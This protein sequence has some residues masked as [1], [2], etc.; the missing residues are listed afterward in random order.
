M[1]VYL[2]LCGVK[3]PVGK[4]PTPFHG[5]FGQDHIK[6][7]HF[8]QKF[9]LAWALPYLD[10]QWEEVWQWHCGSC[11]WPSA[12]RSCC[13]CL[14]CPRRHT[15]WSRPQQSTCGR[16]WLQ[17]S[18]FL[19]QWRSK[20]SN[21]LN[22]EHL[23]TGFIWIPDSMGVHYSNG[24]VTHDFP[25]HL[26]TGHF[27]PLTGFFRPVFRPPF[28]YGT[29]WQL[30]QS[31]VKKPTIKNISSNNTFHMSPPFWQYHRNIQINVTNNFHFALVYLL[32]KLDYSLYGQRNN[33]RI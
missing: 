22:T 17:R 2:Q 18:S 32:G 20:Y 16:P 10:L 8:P 23:N 3:V 21:H 14:W 11:R 9:N 27:G 25:N 24:K 6:R 4:K 13:P 1:P 19:L 29:I 12:N 15:S 28:E 26:N 7:S 5:G 30:E 31:W 33:N